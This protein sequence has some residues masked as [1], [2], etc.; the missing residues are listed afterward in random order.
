MRMLIIAYSEA[1]DEEVMQMLKTNVQAEYTKWTGVLGW[2]Q[3]SEPH[4]LT[5]VWPRANNVLMICVEDQ[6][7]GAIREGVREL[8]QTLGN[9]GVKAFSMGVD[10]V[11]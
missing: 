3:H 11:T 7:A 2:G 4:L 1:I 6:K 8:R 9:E 10:D 5:H